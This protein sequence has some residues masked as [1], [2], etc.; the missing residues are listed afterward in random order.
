MNGNM[1]TYDVVWPL[2]R[3]VVRANVDAPRLATLEGKTICELWNYLYQGDQ[4]FS[5]IEERFKKLYPKVDFISYA[6]FG[7]THGKK[8]REVIEALGAKL[9]ENRCDAVISGIGG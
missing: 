2:G 3:K 7:N 5:L 6:E 4:C 8:E 9:T 1:H